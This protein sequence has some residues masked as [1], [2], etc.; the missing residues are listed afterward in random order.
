MGIGDGII[1]LPYI[2]AIS[3]ALGT[4]VSLLARSSSR[5][6]DLL[7]DNHHIR[8]VITLDRDDQNK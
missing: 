1:F 7:K 2:F 3:E 4:P 6:K 5:A 8:E